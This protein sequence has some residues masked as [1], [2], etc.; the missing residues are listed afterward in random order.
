MEP[1]I[2]G[3]SGMLLVPKGYLAHVAALCKKYNVLLIAD[4]VATG[5]G[6]TGRMFAC[7]HEGVS[8]D[9][10]CVA[11]SI[12]GGYLPLAATLT[13][14]RIYRAFLG[15]YDEFKTFFHGHTYTANPLA[16]AAALANLDLYQK[17]HLL[18]NVKERAQQLQ[19]CLAL[20]AGNPHIKEIRQIGLMVGIE[21]CR[22]DGS[23]YAPGERMGLKVC[24]AA[25]RHGVW[26]RPLGDVIVLAP[27]LAITEKELSFLIDVAKSP[28]YSL[29]GDPSLKNYLFDPQFNRKRKFLQRS[30]FS[31]AFSPII[32][33]SVSGAC[34]AILYARRNPV[35]RRGYR[36]GVVY[37]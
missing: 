17:H 28:L 24:D 37:S 15:R 27:P 19:K 23:P 13:Q 20:L 3:A 29:Q 30:L 35:S 11:K 18:R 33:P 21:L 16:C 25:I 26:L 4:E 34:V 32:R 14:E 12:T 31:K 6:R 9:F 22:P 5:F 10:L 1:L 8:P 36:T 7:E 2:Q